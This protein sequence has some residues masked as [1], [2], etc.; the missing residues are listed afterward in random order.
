MNIEAFSR[1]KYKDMAKPGD[2]VILIE[3]DGVLAVFDG[4]TDPTGAIYHGES[5]GRI[6]AR[7]A[8]RRTAKL[9]ADRK[10]LDASAEEIFQA[11]SDSVKDAATEH[12][13]AHPPSTTAAIVVEAPDHYRLL[14][15]GDTGIRINGTDVYQH[16]KLIDTV[17][18]A[19]RV[20]VHGILTRKIADADDVEMATRKVIFSGL[21]AAVSAGSLTVNE[22]AEAL[23]AAVTAARVSETI[24]ADFLTGGIRT[25]FHHANAHGPLGYAS[26]NGKQIILDGITNLRLPKADVR[27]IEIFSDG[28]VSIPASGVAVHDWEKEF[29]RVELSDFHKTG[30]FPTV[31]GSTSFESCDDRT[32][33]SAIPARS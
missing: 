5:S 27:S 25:Q 9:A 12:N 11:L 21:N 24:A 32:V 6:A 19:A 8:A 20:A 31:K 28:Y 2:D 30:A 13:I 7:S 33:V 4:A 16:H 29:Q 14:A 18:T 1:S 23:A 26:I 17:S 3:P 22:A 15:L 10:L